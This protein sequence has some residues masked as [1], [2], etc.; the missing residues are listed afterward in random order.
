MDV[1]KG[2]GQIVICTNTFCLL[3]EEVTR[4][5]LLF[6]NGLCIRTQQQTNTFSQCVD[7]NWG[8]L[9]ECD[10]VFGGIDEEMKVIW[11]QT[12]GKNA[13]SR[14]NIFSNFLKE[15]IVI[16]FVKEDPSLIVAPVVNVI[17]TSFGE[18]HKL[19]YKLIWGF[20]KVQG[21]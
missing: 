3:L 13:G 8:L 19:K 7:L 12:P 10:S 15:E 11:H 2:G 5:T 4:N 17:K 18:L 21:V 9:Y 14:T 1:M 20:Q 16:S 6:L